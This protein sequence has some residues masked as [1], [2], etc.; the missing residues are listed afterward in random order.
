MIFEPTNKYLQTDK[1]DN[2]Q[3]IDGDFV[4]IRRQLLHSFEL[5]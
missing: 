3:R 4:I 1:S 2:S 5:M